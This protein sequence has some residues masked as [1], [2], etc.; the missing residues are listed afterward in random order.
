[1]SNADTISQLLN[2]QGGRYFTRR[3][4]AR[5]ASRAELSYRGVLLGIDYFARGFDEDAYVEQIKS[6]EIGNVECLA[7]FSE[8]QIS[9]ISERIERGWDQE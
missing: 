3:G 7:I 6:I 8:E 2:D 5:R 9:E 1:M 4:D